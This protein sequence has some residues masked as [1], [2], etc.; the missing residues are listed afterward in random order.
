MYK[1]MSNQS[2]TSSISSDT[3]SRYSYGVG[4]KSA[5]PPVAARPSFLNTNTTRSRSL[6]SPNVP[7]P[8]RRPSFTPSVQQS[9]VNTPPMRASYLRRNTV[10]ESVH[11]DI[12]QKKKRAPP[13]PPPSK[14][15]SSINNKKEYVEALYELKA[16]QEGDLS[17]RAGDLIEVL[18]KSEK[19]EDWWKGR[20]G[21]QTGMFPG[22]F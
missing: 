10:S 5:P 3:S 1:T 2:N 11:E 13:P 16:P 7:P 19:T 6:S 15:F 22:K 8:I 4:G 14:K 17:F 21:D 12:V 20:L 18:E 9:N